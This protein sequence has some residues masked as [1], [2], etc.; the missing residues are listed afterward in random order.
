MYKMMTTWAGVILAA[1]EGTRMKSRTPKALHCVAGKEM[2]SWVK[3]AVSQTTTTVTAAVV[4]PEFPSQH[5]CFSNGTERVL[6]EERLGTGH[7]LLQA[8]PFIAG[9]ADHILV[10]NADMP[11]L[12]PE[13]LNLMIDR[14]LDAEAALTILTC[15][16][17]EPGEMGRVIR[18]TNGEVT[19]IIEWRDA[20]ADTLYYNE[21]CCG[22]Y[23]FRS[24]W[25]WPA[26]QDLAPA[27]NGEFYI[28][29]LVDQARQNGLGIESVSP[30]N[31]D[32]ALGVNDRSDLA[33]VT[34]IAFERTRQ[35]AMSQGVTLIDPPSTFIDATVRVDMD[36]VLQPGVIL[37]GDT[38]IGAACT[39]G[40]NAVIRDS[41][42]GDECTIQGSVIEGS[43]IDSHVEIG[44]YCHLRPGARLAED[45]CIGNYVEVKET[46][47]GPGTR[48]GHFSYLGDAEIGANVNIGAGTVTCNYDGVTKNR[49]IIG[50][51]AFIGSDSMLV[52]PVRIGARAVTGAGSVVTK[53]LPDDTQ[54]FGVPARER[55]RRKR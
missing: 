52:A 6:Q 29:S 15:R 17:E 39:I 10:V 43:S 41:S 45:V 38:S 47:I 9:Q 14:H 48:V 25:L 22:A 32:E 19:D 7:A 3:D 51:G 5:H 37:Q 34:A 49:T 21:V 27:P 36:T 35:K 1:G 13:T 23:C 26:L 42:I 53:D 8:E 31:P 2:L 20:N 28:T 16:L 40:P 55:P 18:D 50:D 54:A 24:E 44:P 30:A 46:R 11:L 4:G 12:S 33:R